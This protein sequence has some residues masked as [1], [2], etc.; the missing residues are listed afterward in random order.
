VS[1]RADLSPGVP[2]ASDR[3]ISPLAVGVAAAI[4]LLLAPLP[5]LG[6]LR[7][8]IFPCLGLVTAATLLLY[9]YHH[10]LARRRVDLSAGTI[11]TAA[12]TLR[13]L[14]LPMLPSLSDDAW[15]YMWDGRL[16]LHG[17]NPYHYA[18]ADPAL[19]RFADG[20]LALQGYPTTHTIYP[21]GAQLLFATAMAIGEITGTGYSGGYFF[22]KIVLVSLEIVAIRLLLLMLDRLHLPR[23]DALLY[24]WHPLVLVELAGQGH[25]DAL[26]VASIAIF[27]YMLSS[28]SSVGATFGIMFGALARL[29]TLLLIPLWWRLSGGREREAGV[30]VLA[31][32]MLLFL[33]LIE[34]RA[35]ESFTSVGVRFTN[36]Y[37]FNG[38]FYN[39]VKWTLDELH[40]APSNAIAGAI[41]VAIQ[42]LLFVT[43]WWWAGKSPEMWR[44]DSASSAPAPSV[45]WQS[46]EG[47]TRSR[48]RRAATATLA[49]V[50]AQMFFGT[51]VHI[52]YFVAPLYLSALL[53]ES[54]FRRA[55]LWA[56]LVGPFTY[57][58]YAWTPHA[59]RA[60]VIAIEWGGFLC[61]V[62]VELM[63]RR[64]HRI[65]RRTERA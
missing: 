63:L 28:R 50:T 33:P 64:R 1:A 53:P 24:A 31:V 19:S 7:D 21:P 23:R 18:P 59:E 60:E 55:W 41:G 61:I 51:K 13:L 5:Y 10:H 42:L 58:Y 11:I 3:A 32:M 37:E 12:I 25:T 22:W 54:I 57:L 65:A 56:A 45:D 38:G 2:P 35:F 29:F 49:I 16:V 44:G 30:G 6:N 40:L 15:R 14:L 39:A 26:W 9:G 8:Q 43:V 46:M 48:L 20:L 36:Y 17:I 34:P 52:W 47:E 62:I 4:A 27:L